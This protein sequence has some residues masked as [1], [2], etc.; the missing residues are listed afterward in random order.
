VLVIDSSGK[1]E[2]SIRAIAWVMYVDREGARQ[3]S[4][5]ETTKM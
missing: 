1:C 2:L 3:V 4:V 5:E